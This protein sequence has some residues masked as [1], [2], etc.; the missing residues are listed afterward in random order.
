MALYGF[1][2][3]LFDQY[4]WRWR[5]LHFF[6]VVRVPCLLGIWHGNVHPTPTSGVSAGRQVETGMQI[7]I[8]QTWTEIFISGATNQSKFH[9]LSASISI[10]EENSI[11]YEYV[12]DPSADAVDTMHTHHGTAQLIINKLVTELSG[13]YYSG[14]DRQNFGSLRFKKQS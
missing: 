1:F 12:N 8:K 3:W 7:E 5:P 2:Y 6:G 9:S 4:I 11:L 14:R 10:D 13:E